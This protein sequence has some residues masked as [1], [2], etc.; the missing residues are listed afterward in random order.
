MLPFSYLSRSSAFFVLT[1]GLILS[2]CSKSSDSSKGA[3]P[4]V[5]S[6]T[7]TVGQLPKGLEIEVKDDSVINEL[8]KAGS[9]YFIQDGQVV[10][11]INSIDKSKN[12]CYL[13]RSDSSLEVKPGDVLHMTNVQSQGNKMAIVSSD[14]KVVMGCMKFSSYSDWTVQQLKGVFGEAANVKAAE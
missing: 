4:V 6:D 3:A 12:L 14:V 5:G 10:R 2:A 9:S 8:L 1:T 11:S 13:E 7:R